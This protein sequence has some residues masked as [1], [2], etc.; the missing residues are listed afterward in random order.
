MDISTETEK[1]QREN[2]L[3]TQLYFCSSSVISSH[4]NLFVDRLHSSLNQTE[5]IDTEKVHIWLI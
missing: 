5:I 2:G 3:K 4:P 1:N